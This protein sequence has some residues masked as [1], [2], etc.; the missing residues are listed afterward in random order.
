[1]EKMDINSELLL[2]KILNTTS[3]CIFWKDTQRRFLGV[4]QAF[5]DYYGFSSQEMLLGKTDEDM[6]WHSDPDP[7]Q[8][9][10]WKVLKDGISTF[11]TH[12]KCMAR[13]EERDILASK[14][15]IYEDGRIIGLVG[16]FEDV[17]E[18]YRKDDKIRRLAETLAI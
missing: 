3:T 2:G 7:F 14:S 6:G 13:G 10:E 1:M 12:G 8:N 18:E 9:D 5:L 17:T 16:T 11:R 15:P 4:N